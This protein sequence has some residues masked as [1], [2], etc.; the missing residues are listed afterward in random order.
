MYTGLIFVIE[1][2]WYP[3][4]IQLSVLFLTDV[5]CNDTFLAFLDMNT[6]Q[7]P[8]N[9]VKASARQ[10]V[11]MELLQTEKNYVGILSTILKVGVFHFFPIR[12]YKKVKHTAVVI[13]TY[14]VQ[15]YMYQYL[16]NCSCKK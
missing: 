4:C 11:T 10:L 3:V 7:S 1:L 2:F 6:R 9:T 13:E 15:N 12:L 5:Q 8:V 14:H 16:M